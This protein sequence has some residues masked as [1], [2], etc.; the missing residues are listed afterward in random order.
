M[1]SDLD[2]IIMLTM[3]E[4]KYPSGF[5]QWT[6]AKNID[7][8]SGRGSPLEDD[9]NSSNEY[10]RDINKA[11]IYKKPTPVQVVKVD[12]PNRAHAKIVEAYYRKPST[13]DYNGIYKG[14]YIDFEAKETKDSRGLPLFMIHEHQIH[15]LNKVIYHGGIGFYIVRFIK[16]NATML[17][18]AGIMNAA[19]KN[20]DKSYIPYSW[21]LENGYLIPESYTPRIPYL[22][23]VDSLYFKEDK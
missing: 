5:N 17:I 6:A 14:K 23:V 15:H 8:H 18:D 21:F 22:K 2:F 16:K 7:N 10:Y 9:L 13:T 3:S 20:W 1:N 11:L 12:Y 4:L 19:I